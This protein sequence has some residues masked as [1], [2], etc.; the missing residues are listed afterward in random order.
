MVFHDQNQ[1]SSR[2]PSPTR[3]M[4]RTVQQLWIQVKYR[5]NNGS[6]LDLS[7]KFLELFFQSPLCS[8]VF[9]LVEEGLTFG[10]E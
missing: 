9:V 2:A 1:P 6:E 5:F 4:E 7:F 10:G 8:G 3:K